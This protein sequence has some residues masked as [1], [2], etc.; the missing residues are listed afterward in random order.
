MA[1]TNYNPILKST[2]LIVD[3]SRYVKINDTF[4]ENS[5]QRYATMEMKIPNW[6]GPMF[7]EDSKDKTAFLLIGNAI[8]F[9]Y[10]NFDTGQKWESTPG[11]G[12][13]SMSGA[14][15]MWASLMKAIKIGE[16]IL[17]GRYLSCL[18]RKQGERIF[19]GNIEIPLLDERLENLR[20]LGDCLDVDYSN[21]FNQLVS[22]SNGE[23]FSDKG[24]ISRLNDMAFIF[25]DWVSLK[26]LGYSDNTF[27]IAFINKRAQLAAG[28]L[29][30]AGLFSDSEANKLTVFAD[31]NLP[32]E[33]RHQGV[34]EYSKNLAEKIDSQIPI[35]VGSNEEVEIRV[36]TIHAADR[37]INKV[38][39]LRGGENLINA[40]HLDAQLF[41]DGRSRKKKG[42]E[43]Y[44]HH[45]TKTTTY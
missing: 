1:E 13:S 14:F 32:N 25:D 6:R 31:Y 24:L 33:L 41:F 37:I 45:L 9:A 8:N 26:N 7:P 22:D 39:E 18:T 44:P 36:A 43:K 3:N 4:L 20:V 21:S 40:L 29:I 15:G 23:L 2:Q 38:N 17:D 30:G 12:L 19:A 5:A 42:I 27:D 11:E 28:M 10:S 35:K 34:I 16:P